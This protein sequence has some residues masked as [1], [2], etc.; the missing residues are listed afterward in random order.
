MRLFPRL[1]FEA[2]T[3]YDESKVRILPPEVAHQIATGEVIE[4]PA[5]AV[6]ELVENTLDA[7]ASRVEVEIEGRRDYS[8]RAGGRGPGFLEMAHSGPCPLFVPIILG[9]TPLF[10]EGGPY[11]TRANL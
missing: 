2:E 5:S 6:K 8:C 10:A 4:R 11:R 3:P 7:G 9:G 1:I